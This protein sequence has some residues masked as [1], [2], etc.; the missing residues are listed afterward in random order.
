MDY[1]SLNIHICRIISNREKGRAATTGER[2]LRVR[3]YPFPADSVIE[4][5]VIFLTENGFVYYE[6]RFKAFLEYLSNA[7]INKAPS[8]WS[9]FADSCGSPPGADD[10]ANDCI[11][12]QAAC[13]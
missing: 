2:L 6:T 10:I 1:N 11:H 8:D 7:R 3:P 5:L 9:P 4:R 13:D 12:L